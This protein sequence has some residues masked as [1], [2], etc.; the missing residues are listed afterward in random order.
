MPAPLRVI[1]APAPSD[2]G[3]TAPDI[4]RSLAARRVTVELN[5]ACPPVVVNVIDELDDT[6]PIWPEKFALVAFI[7]TVM[8]PG[9][10]TCAPD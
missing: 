1:V 2:A 7:G 6:E 10:L 5:E 8:A 3:L 9:T 4:V